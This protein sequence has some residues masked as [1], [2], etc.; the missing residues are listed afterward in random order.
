MRWCLPGG[1]FWATGADSQLG[2][3][4]P[5]VL[6]LAEDHTPGA[7]MFSR[8]GVHVSCSLTRSLPLPPDVFCK[9]PL[10]RLHKLCCLPSCSHSNGKPPPL[11]SSAARHQLVC[12]QC[13]IFIYTLNFPFIL[14]LRIGC[15]TPGLGEELRSTGK[16]GLTHSAEPFPSLRQILRQV[17][18]ELA[19]HLTD[20]YPAR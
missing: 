15:R 9:Q 3:I 20:R 1:I 17:S 14:S 19:G 10:Q 11:V 2:R 8:P 7:L 6:G 12:T 13:S 4:A 18:Q 5:V 16:G